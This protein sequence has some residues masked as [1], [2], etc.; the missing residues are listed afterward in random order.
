MAWGWHVGQA[1]IPTRAN[2]TI[3]VDFQNEATHFQLVGDGKAFVTYVLAFVLSLGFQLK[4]KVTCRGKKRR[5]AIRCHKVP[6]PR[7]ANGKDGMT[8]S[9]SG[10]RQQPCENLR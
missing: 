9:Y 2:R 8:S 10:S 4:H 7:S 3:T 6:L 1:A 5:A